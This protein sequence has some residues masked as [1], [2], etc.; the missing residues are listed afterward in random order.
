MLKRLGKQFRIGVAPGGVALARTSVW[1]R[2]G[3]EVLAE[4]A[5]PAGASHEQLAA[6]VGEALDGAIPR[7]A[8]VSVV[9]ADDL[10]RIWQVTP[11]AGCTRMS[12]LQAA[13]GMRFQTLF[14]ASTTGWRIAADWDASRPF[15]AAA[16]PEPLVGAIEEAVRG[17]RGQ[18]VEVVPQFVAA[19]NEW[20]AQIR[21]G[22]WFGM[23]QSEVLT[24]ALFDGAAFAAVRSVPV[25]PDAGP[26]WLDAHVARE[27]LR[28]G[29][30]RPERLL[31]CG[32]APASWAGGDGCEL[33]AS[34]Q[35]GLS[36][37]AAVA[38]TGSAR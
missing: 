37:L 29:V 20:R 1:R 19:L 26:D 21:P 3:I 15:L 2:A 13:A 38:C 23:I 27:A 18:V 14:G 34:A 6:A 16:A 10:A 31:V 25:S 33:L 8:A 7:N 22:A 24:L 35:S 32:P 30:A 36:G 5:L 17:Q 11:P 9:L 4:R 12:D 28:V